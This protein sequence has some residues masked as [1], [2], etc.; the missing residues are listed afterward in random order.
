MFPITMKIFM[1]TAC[2][3]LLI[4]GENVYLVGVSVLKQCLVA[5]NLLYEIV[6]LYYKSSFHGNQLDTLLSEQPTYFRRNT[7]A[8]AEYALQI[9]QTRDV[10]NNSNHTCFL[11]KSVSKD[12]EN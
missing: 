5:E 8:K 3:L 4:A 11:K 6:L 12:A 10:V 2:R 1:N 7:F 9:R